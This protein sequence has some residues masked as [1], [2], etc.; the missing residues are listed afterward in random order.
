MCKLRYDQIYI[1]AIQQFLYQT[2]YYSAYPPSNQF[3]VLQQPGQISEPTS[4]TMKFLSVRSEFI[5]NWLIDNMNIFV[6]VYRVFWT[7]NVVLLAFPNI[8]YKM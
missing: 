5:F 1:I 4:C 6:W 2:G 7:S 8:M 3:Y